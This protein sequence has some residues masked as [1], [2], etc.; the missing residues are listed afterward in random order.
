[1]PYT[2]IPR[3]PAAFKELASKSES[4]ANQALRIAHVF[5]MKDGIRMPGMLAEDGQAWHPGIG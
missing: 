3:N 5:G 2:S 1:M 4:Q